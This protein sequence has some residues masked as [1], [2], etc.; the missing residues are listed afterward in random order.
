MK[1]GI[2]EFFAKQRGISLVQQ[3]ILWKNIPEI[4]KADVSRS[5]TEIKL[6]CEQRK[7]L[8]IKTR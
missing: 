1:T 3:A 5:V 6:V 8:F 4:L 7:S 2:S